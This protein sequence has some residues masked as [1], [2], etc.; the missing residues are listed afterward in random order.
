MIS[1]GKQLVKRTGIGLMGGGK[2]N[3]FIN[4]RS[5]ADFR[6]GKLTVSVQQQS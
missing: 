3:L 1:R 2:T 5:Q 6:Q 4:A